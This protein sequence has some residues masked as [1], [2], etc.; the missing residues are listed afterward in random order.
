[1]TVL[2]SVPNSE[3]ADD[4]DED[5]METEDDQSEASGDQNL[6]PLTPS[7]PPRTYQHP[8]LSI[9]TTA[10]ALQRRK[11]ETSR[12][13][14][15]HAPRTAKRV[16]SPQASKPRTRSHPSYY[17]HP[18][19]CL[20]K[21]CD[22]TSWTSKER[23][24][25]MDTHFPKRFKCNVCDQWFSRGSSL[26]RH[27]DQ[28]S[29]KSATGCRG[30][31][32]RQEHTELPA[33]WSQ[34]ENINQLR[35]PEPSDLLYGTLE[36]LF[37]RMENKRAQGVSIEASNVV[38]PVKERKKNK[39]HKQRSVETTG[40][41]PPV[42]DDTVG[43]LNS[44][45]PA[46]QSRNGRNIYNYKC[47]TT[48]KEAPSRGDGGNDSRV[49]GRKGSPLRLK[50]V[51][52]RAQSDKA[53]SSASLNGASTTTPSRSNEVFTPL[54]VLAQAAS[55][56]LISSRSVEVPSP[57]PT[58]GNTNPRSSGSKVDDVLNPDPDG[59]SA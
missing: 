36:P 37:R 26:K 8:S 7:F 31:W 3:V 9:I 46:L 2:H 58:P 4:D 30:S 47:P 56:I 19:P 17:G 51:D 35:R 43:K 16:R 57:E 29:A 39:G 50:Q 14:A 25:H 6:S 23:H 21:G 1:M 32:G 15:A 44:N 48:S 22:H 24:K 10:P 40:T 42:K 20:F 38:S 11:A 49:A 34:P 54:E 53:T 28:P 41:L 27:S 52:A 18:Q 45:D 55:Q 5:V 59:T 13:R 33:F 12:E